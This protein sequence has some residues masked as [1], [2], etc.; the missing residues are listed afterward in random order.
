MRLNRK[1]L[2]CAMLDADLNTKQLA[3]KAGIARATACSIKN[4]KSC[5]YDTAVKLAAALGIP[6]EELIEK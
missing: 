2:V 4:G 5:N 6:V 3:E 1:K